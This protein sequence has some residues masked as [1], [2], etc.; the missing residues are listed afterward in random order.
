MIVMLSTGCRQS[1][2]RAP[3]FFDAPAQFYFL[4]DSR[5]FGFFFFFFVKKKLVLMIFSKMIKQ[6]KKK[7]LLEQEPFWLAEMNHEFETKDRQLLL[8]HM[9]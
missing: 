5:L 4:S 8:D 6:K 7:K 1:F 2:R 3:A 9:V